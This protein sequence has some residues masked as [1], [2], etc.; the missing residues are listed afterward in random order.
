VVWN[1][2]GIIPDEETEERNYCALADTLLSKALIFRYATM[3]AQ[4]N[5]SIDKPEKFRLSDQ[6]YDEFVT[7][8]QTQ[9]HEY[10]TREEKDLEAM[11]RHAMKNNTF[12]AFSDDY[13]T[14]RKKIDKAKSDDFTE[15]K[16]EI[17]VLLESEIASRYYYASGRVAASLKDDS[18]LT[19]A[20]TIL[21]DNV[22]YRN[23][24]TQVVKK[25]KPK[26]RA[27]LEQQDD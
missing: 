19:S 27:E 15:Y 22:R 20:M 2:L 1:G 5:P 11:K 21:H 24:L 16:S 3:F 14:M 25:D 8:A 26:Q 9:E 7:W 12:T 18:D 6:Q 23:I 13:A 4:K 10:L 17:K